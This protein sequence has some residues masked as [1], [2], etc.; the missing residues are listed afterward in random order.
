MHSPSHSCTD[1]S[2]DLGLGT[3]SGYVVRKTFFDDTPHADV[4]AFD[5]PNLYG[6]ARQVARQV[7]LANPNGYAVVDPVYS[8]GCR[9]MG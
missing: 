2:I 3:I 5:R 8:C 7:G 4:A 1:P 9:G 6:D